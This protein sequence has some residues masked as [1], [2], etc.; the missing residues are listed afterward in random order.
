MGRRCARLWAAD[1]TIF[2]VAHNGDM[3]LGALQAAELLLRSVRIKNA[4][5]ATVQFNSP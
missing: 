1:D 2:I 3:I 5:A 4:S